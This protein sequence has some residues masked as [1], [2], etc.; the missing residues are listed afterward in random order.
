M[1]LGNISGGFLAGN[2]KKKAGLNCYAYNFSV[3]YRAFDADNIIDIHKYLIKKTWYKIMLEIIF[4][5]FVVL[6][7][8]IVNASNHIKSVSL[9]NQKCI[10]QPTLINLNLN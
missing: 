10:I 3:D 7:S 8:S 5:M 2:M 4:K 1:C 9:N 6:L